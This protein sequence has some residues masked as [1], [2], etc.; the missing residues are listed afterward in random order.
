MLIQSFV[1]MI[2]EALPHSIIINAIEVD[3]QPFLRVAVHLAYTVLGKSDKVKK[4]RGQSIDEGLTE[5]ISL[6]ATQYID[7]NLNKFVT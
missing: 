2:N 6:H 1:L 4:Q 5:F 3:M 7:F